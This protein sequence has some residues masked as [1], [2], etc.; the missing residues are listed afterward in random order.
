M[1][2]EC[3]RATLVI[4]ELLWHHLLDEGQLMLCLLKE[5]FDFSFTRC[6]SLVVQPSSRISCLWHGST[7]TKCQTE[8]TRLDH[9]QRFLFV[10]YTSSASSH[11]RSLSRSWGQISQKLASLDNADTLCL[12]A[13]AM[14]SLVMNAACQ[15]SSNQ[16]SYKTSKVKLKVQNKLGTK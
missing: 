8:K 13:S 10:D 14:A 4:S 15:S 11:S 1:T 16:S 5:K 3:N 12:T 7:E 6:F 9:V 2:S